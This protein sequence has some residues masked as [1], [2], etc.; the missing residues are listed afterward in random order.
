MLNL[1]TLPK[2]NGFSVHKKPTFASLVSTPPSGR[3]VTNFQQAVP[4]WE[5]E[6]TYEV[7]RER[8]QN[9]IPWGPFSAFDE[10]QQISQVFLACGGQYGW[11]YYDDPTDDSRQ[12]QN[13]G[14]GDGTTKNF[15]FIRNLTGYGGLVVSE[16]VGGVDIGRTLNV[17]LNGTLQDPATYTVSSSGTTLKFVTP[18]GSGVVVSADFYFFYLCRF[19]TDDVDFEEFMY[20]R[21]SVKSL[22]FRSL[23]YGVL[24]VTNLVTGP[25]TSALNHIAIW[26]NT[27]GSLL[28]DSG[29]DAYLVGN[30]TPVAGTSMKIDNLLENTIHYPLANE[31]GIWP[32]ST[33]YAY[34]A[35]SKEI[36]TADI[37]GT[38]PTPITAFF[39]YTNNTIPGADGVGALFDGVA[40]VTN[41]HIWGFNSVARTGGGGIT[42]KVV[43]GEID[44]EYISGDNNT[45]DSG[46][47]FINVFGG[48]EITGVG[49]AIQIGGVGGFW[50]NGIVIAQSY[51]AGLAVNSGDANL[52]SLVDSETAGGFKEAA[53][54]VGSWTNVNNQMVKWKGPSGGATVEY[55]DG[56]N[57]H[58]LRNLN[59]NVTIDAIAGDSVTISTNLVASAQFTGAPTSGNTGLALLIHNTGGITLANVTLGVPDSGGAGFRLLRVGN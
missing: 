38:G 27:T 55:Q 51:G 8:T 19:V 29:T 11:F 31:A 20:N 28:G 50:T 52:T 39:A 40:R 16:P 18:P 3:E 10:L 24:D 36:T 43:G 49:P 5:F 47:L 13:L 4:L 21:W 34:F 22:R 37:T 14:T 46:G 53:V 41:S 32:G 23:N 45:S 15:L 26:E 48:N 44:V 9:Q 1:P 58:F 42:A 12:N 59:G 54:I 7:L 35:I 30:Q 2:L 33:V 56:S 25:N 57:N 6:L 17:Y